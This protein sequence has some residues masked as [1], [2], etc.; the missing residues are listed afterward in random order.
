MV[1]LDKRKIFISKVDFSKDLESKILNL[2]HDFALGFLAALYRALNTHVSK[3]P[4]KSVVTRFRC[5][6]TYEIETNCTANNE[7]IVREV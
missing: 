4:C 7:T 3:Q 6:G 1:N 2:G 5:G